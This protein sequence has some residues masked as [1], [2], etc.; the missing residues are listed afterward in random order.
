MNSNLT[1]ISES[2]SVDFADKIR[3][4]QETGRSI[5]SMHIGEPCFPTHQQAKNA[6]KLALKQ[7]DTRYSNSQGLIALREIISN[8]IIENKINP[9]IP[10]SNNTLK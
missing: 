10:V 9:I 1:K 5:I 4:I 7:D 3:V 8:K 2:P 6:L